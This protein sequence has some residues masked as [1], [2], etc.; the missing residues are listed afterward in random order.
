MAFGVIFT[1]V[2]APLAPS[3]AQ[4]LRPQET[5]ASSRSASLFVEPDMD[6][7]P[8]ETWERIDK[9][10]DTAL[11][12]LASR[13]Q[14]DGSFPTYVSGQ[15]GVTA[16]VAMAFLSA[17][18][19][20]GA[21]KHGEAI[22]RAIDYVLSCQRSD[23][24]FVVD[25][26]DMPVTH[27]LRGAHTGLYNHAIA[28][29]MLC[30][31]YGSV[32]AAREK[33]LRS[34]I[35]R[36]LAFARKIQLRVQPFPE[37]KGGFRYFKTSFEHDGA[38]NADLSVTGWFVMFYRSAQNAGFNVPED[39]AAEA[40]R[41]VRHCYHPQTGGFHYGRSGTG[42][43]EPTRGMTGAGIV[44]LAASGEADRIISAAAGEWILAH[45]FD[46]YGG[47]VGDLDR[48]HYGAY[49][50]SQAMFFLGGDYWAEFYPTLADTLM[51][52]QLPEGSW[53][54]E[55]AHDK[56]FGAEYSTALS[57]LTLTTPYQLLPIHQR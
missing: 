14:A 13:Q 47:T 30:D 31:A 46:V 54:P 40:T 51:A 52:N 55:Q 32:D 56:L 19:Q 22:N 41:Y 8:P 33:E 39:Y 29:L 42:P 17:G 24:V 48:F 15:P 43:R 21:G 27:S 53:P 57:V 9:S 11:D 28:C 20:P 38:G 3:L 1:L 23:D 50:C 12:W 45:P 16:L 36:G 44:C 49:Y 4:D 18:E 25:S 6:S 34:G 2:G 10:V 7:V 26:T 35:E 37:D 5:V